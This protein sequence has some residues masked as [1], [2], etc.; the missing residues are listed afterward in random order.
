[1]HSC[2]IDEINDLYCWGNNGNGQLGKG[3]NS[4]TIANATPALP[5]NHSTLQSQG[6]TAKVATGSYHTCALTF[7]GNIFCWGANGSGQLGNG[8]TISHYDPR[9]INT[10]GVPVADRTFVDISTNS[11]ST[12]A[13]TSTG[14][15][16]CWGGNQFGKLG[17]RVNNT[18]NMPRPA[19]VQTD[20]I[21]TGVISTGEK[22]TCAV[23][24]H[25]TNN[26]N[27]VICWGEN[28][29][30]QLGVG[31]VSGP[32]F[33]PTPIPEL[34]SGLPGTHTDDYRKVT[35]VSSGRYFNCAVIE[36]GETFCWGMGVDGRLG[37]GDTV[38]QR[39]PVRVKM[40]NNL[41]AAQWVY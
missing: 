36:N 28:S 40:D 31:T 9:P 19:Q 8:N 20:Y 1:M 29:V 14:K 27:S 12:C 41:G 22:P 3:H 39:S 4:S 7:S 37:N 24:T 38:D 21:F 26:S 18:G 15:A 30:G 34:S 2:A 11:S 17:N 13:V 33:D 6:G 10:S 32:V 23:A 5:S 35:S 25:P 16:Y